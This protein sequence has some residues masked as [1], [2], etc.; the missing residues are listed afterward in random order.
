MSRNI[1]TTH[2]EFVSLLSKSWGAVYMVFKDIPSPEFRQ[3]IGTLES[4]EAYIEVCLGDIPI[5][6]QNFLMC[7][8]LAGKESGVVTRKVPYLGVFVRY[9]GFIDSCEDTESIHRIIERMRSEKRAARSF[10]DKLGVN[11]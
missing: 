3:S 2:A 4:D 6:A 8:Q 9:I 11:G 1:V 10:Y 5:T 7:R